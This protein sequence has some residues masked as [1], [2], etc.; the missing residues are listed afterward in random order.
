LI[1]AGM[2]PQA[3]SFMLHIKRIADSLINDSL[4]NFLISI[5]NSEELNMVAFRINTNIDKAALRAVKM[6]IAIQSRS[7][8]QSK[9]SI[10]AANLIRS[11]A[12]KLSPEV[13][14]EDDQEIA[15]KASDVVIPDEDTLDL[16]VAYLKANRLLI[17][18]LKA[19]SYTSKDTTEKISN[20][21]LS[22]PFYKN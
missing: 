22:I 17:S 14:L 9:N 21:L 19:E 20:E 10:L 16:F 6:W 4:A 15:I 12:F 5:E 7:I 1:L 8:Y 13:K 18:C 2:L 3:D 11:I